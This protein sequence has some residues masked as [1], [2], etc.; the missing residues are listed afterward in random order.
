MGHRFNNIVPNKSDDI[1]CLGAVGFGRYIKR[2]SKPLKEKKAEEEIEN[3][4]RME[5]ENL[6]DH[7]HMQTPLLIIE[8]K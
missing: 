1:Y 2:V 5:M 8:T 6:I 3:D 4:N 7:M